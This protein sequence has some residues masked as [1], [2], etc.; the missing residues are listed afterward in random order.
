MKQRIGGY[1]EWR[2]HDAEAYHKGICE[3]GWILDL[4]VRAK[5]NSKKILS[6]EEKSGFKK[7]FF[8]D[9]FLSY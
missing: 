7:D 6:K 8:K 1:Q 9:I 4:I 5:R 3:S 2:T